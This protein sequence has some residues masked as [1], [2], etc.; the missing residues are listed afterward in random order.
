MNTRCYYDVTISRIWPSAVVTYAQDWIHLIVWS[1]LAFI[2]IHA[3]YVSL[4]DWF[5]IAQ[6]KTKKPNCSFSLHIYTCI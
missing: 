1:V 4:P 6:H 2:A 3:A 5:V